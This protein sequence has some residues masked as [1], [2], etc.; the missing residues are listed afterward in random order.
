[1]KRLQRVTF[2]LCANDGLHFDFDFAIPAS[3]M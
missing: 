3:P 2:E 1:V